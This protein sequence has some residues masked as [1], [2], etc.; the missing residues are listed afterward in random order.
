M[1]K[2]LLV[3]Q[4]PVATRSG[5]GDHSRDILKSLFALDKFDIKIVPTRWGNTPQ[6]QITADNEFGQRVLSNIIT[7]L[8]QKPAVYIQ[9]SVANEFNPIGEYNIGI[10]AGVETTGVPKDFIEGC[11]RMNLIIVPST[12]TKQTLE[13]TGYNQVDKN[14]N[15]VVG[16]FKLT[17]PVHVLHE[18]LDLEVFNKI[19]WI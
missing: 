1:S 11:N 5:Y 18:G 16:V 19:E 9:V 10:T 14:T 15:Q 2:P 17:T 8:D 6:N 4:A 7:T 13:N 3:F 12:F